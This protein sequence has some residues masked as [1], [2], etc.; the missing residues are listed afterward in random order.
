M[1]APQTWRYVTCLVQTTIAKISRITNATTAQRTILRTLR[2][3]LVQTAI[4]ILRTQ[5]VLITRRIVRTALR[6]P[7]LTTITDKSV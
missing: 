1:K 2:M 5:Q 4:R 6:I 3:K 7:I